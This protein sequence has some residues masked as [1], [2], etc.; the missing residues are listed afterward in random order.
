[1]MGYVDICAI[2]PGAKYDI[3]TMGSAGMDVFYTPTPIPN[4]PE[5]QNQKVF[6]EEV[7]L[8]P[9]ESFLFPTG[10]VMDPSHIT[11]PPP[12]TLAMQVWA[13]SG[14]SVKKNL[15]TGAG[16]IDEDYRG[17]FA[18][19]LYN[20]GDSPQTIKAGDKIGQIVFAVVLRP[21][22]LVNMVGADKISLTKRGAN[23]FGST[24]G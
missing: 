14:L 4:V 23:G 16:L 19:H 9:G 24:G 10:L 7:T 2:R 6:P 18:I 11:L 22:G 12:M 13:R 5:G 3:G 15:E 20:L 1:M 17:E 21:A 8:Q